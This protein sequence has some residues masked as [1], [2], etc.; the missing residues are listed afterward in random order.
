MVAKPST[1]SIEILRRLV[2]FDTTSRNSNLPLLEY[3]MAYL[4]ELAV[5]YRLTFDDT[6]RKANL[7]ATLG[8][9][10]VPGGYVLSGHTDVVPVD[11]QDWDTDPFTLTEKD[12]KLYGRGTT[13]MKSFDAVVLASFPEFLRRGLH[14]PIHVAL[15]YDEEV[16]LAGVGSLIADM[17]EN[18]F[19]PEGCVVGEPTNMRVIASHKGKR[20]YRCHVS[21]LEAH[22]SLAPGG[23][24]AV[25]Y[26]GAIIARLQELSRKFRTEGPFD[27]EYDCS[28]TTIHVGLV[29]GGTAL[30]IV[31]A[32]C[33]FEFEFRHLPNDDPD[34]I[35]RDV[36]GFV[37]TELLPE[38]RAVYPGAT[39]TFEPMAVIPSLDTPED[40]PV[41][42]LAKAITG[43]NHVRKVSYN[44][45]ACLFH[46][47]GVPTIICGPGNID[48]A[49]KPNE[50]IDIE[51]IAKCEDF[52]NGLMDRVCADN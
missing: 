47:A 25:E 17:C 36:Q 26:A 51:Q 42:Q 7:F 24:N 20:S 38:M 27:D 3:V 18:G 15:S 39:I 11:G 5:P 28:H 50:S 44:C 23:V 14:V 22:S 29:R 21:G 37:D 48:Q 32:E 34:K 45:E 43:E 2:S 30:N 16:G 10:E 33:V 6:G 8:P 1:N 52:M 13:D 31:P 4:D 41:T 40:A 49:H 19:T 9:A 35:F 46:G 12:G